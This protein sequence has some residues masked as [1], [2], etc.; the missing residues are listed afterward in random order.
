MKKAI[1]WDSGEKTE[2]LLKNSIGCEMLFVVDNDEM[3]CG[4][5]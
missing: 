5:C 3:K 2:S 4:R 1:V